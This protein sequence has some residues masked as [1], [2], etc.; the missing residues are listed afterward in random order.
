MPI[1]KKVLNIGLVGYQFMGKAHSNAWLQAP[2]YFDLPLNPILHTLVGRSQAPLEATAER[3]GW[4]KTQTDY[5]K[6]LADQEID[7][8]DVGVPNNL[9]AEIVLAA[10][11][12]G[13]AI[14]C[15]KPLARTLPEAKAMVAAV[16][17]AKVK[18]FVWFNYRR[19]PALAFA[20]HLVQSGRIGQ[21][22]HFR[23]LYLQQWIRD[24]NIPL[25]WRITKKGSGSGSLG[26]LAA[27]SIDLVRYLTGDEF[28]D[29]SGL[30]HTYIK[31]RPLGRM[32]E[33]LTAAPTGKKAGPLGKVDVDDAVWFTA[34]LA[35]GGIGTFEATRFATGHHNDNSIEINGS[36]GSIRFSFPN[37][38][39]LEFYD[40]ALPRS[41]RGWRTISCSTGDHPFAGRYWPADH[42]IG[43]AET[44]VNTAVDIIDHMAGKTKQFH[45]N[46]ED[47]LRTQE[48]LEAVSRSAN[49]RRWVSLKEVR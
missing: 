10:A 19:T 27:H 13:K 26:D 32:V 30:L 15:E 20:R 16:K 14:A 1:A 22:Y 33:G 38:S 34:R 40:D 3:W 35:S 45:A 17:K 25:T 37:F 31:K 2:H 11:E 47:G 4:K 21:V 24:A 7:L 29:V 36:K 8:V 39:F 42:P 41:E 12:A 46:F 43:Y 18:N 49:E 28:A 44:F 5:R 6:M 9:H 23:A 48:V